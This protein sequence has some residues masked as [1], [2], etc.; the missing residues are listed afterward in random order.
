MV[1]TKH[2]LS[3]AFLAVALVLRP[4]LAGAQAPKP[5]SE[6][7]VLQLSNLLSQVEPLLKR[8]EKAGVDAKVDDDAVKRLKQAGVPDAVLAAIEKARNKAPLK[9]EPG[10]TKSVSIPWAKGKLLCLAFSPDGRT[11]ALGGESDAVQL[12][13][14]GTGEARGNLPGHPGD[15]FSLAF[16]PDSKTLAVGTYKQVW[17]WDVEPCKPKGTLKGHPDN[18][19]WVGFLDG[20]KTLASISSEAENSNLM[21][22]NLIMWDV[23]TFKVKRQ[24]EDLKGS[25]VL[26]PD[27]KYLA[28]IQLSI[29]VHACQLHLW[30]MAKTEKVRSLEGAFFYF[31]FAPDN[32][33]FVV[34]YGENLK[35]LQVPSAAQRAGHGLHTDKVYSVAI[36]PDGQTLASGGYDK[37]AILW[38]IAKK[39][40]W[41]HLKGQ[42]HTGPVLVRFSPCGKLLA[43]ASAKDEFVKLW[44]VATGKEQAVLPGHTQGVAKLQFSPDG[45][46]LAVVCGDATVKLWP[47]AAFTAA[48]K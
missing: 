15:G 30:E 35:V 18:V 36:S 8:L 7:E 20:G 4:G 21:K 26:S 27:G 19:R 1:Q 34:G 25:L 38:N 17:L 29:F 33:S 9:I 12:W 28:Q 46:T 23:D 32:Q 5:L 24:L 6:D 45:Q 11:V 10:E 48:A 14:V 16:A 3:L 37:T 13:D 47:V 2:V 40:E 22:S 44:E 42:G 39:Q 41:P 43:T 31:A